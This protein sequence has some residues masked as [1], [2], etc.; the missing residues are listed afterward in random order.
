MLSTLDSPFEKEYHQGMKTVQTL[1]IDLLPVLRENGVSRSFVFGSYAR[2]EAT[3]GSDLDLLV[4]FHE[5]KSLLDLIGLENELKDRLG[6]D[7]D[8]VTEDSLHPALRPQVDREKIRV[9]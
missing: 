4:S 6:M 8:L 3:E 9:L 2:N 5:P 7:V 1:T